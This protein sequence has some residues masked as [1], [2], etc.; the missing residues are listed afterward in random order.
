MDNYVKD[1]KNECLFMFLSLLTTKEV[2][3]KM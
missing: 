3:E 2:F 1:N